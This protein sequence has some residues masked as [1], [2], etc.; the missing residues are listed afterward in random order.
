MVVVRV[1]FGEGLELKNDQ[2]Q[3]GAIVT[4]GKHLSEKVRERRSAEGWAE[5][6]ECIAP[7]VSDTLVPVRCDATRGKFLAG[8]VA[9][10]RKDQRGSARGLLMMHVRQDG[11]ADR[12]P[13]QN[14]AFARCHI[15]D[16]FPARL[17]HI[18]HGQPRR[19]FRRS[20]VSRNIDGDA[21]IPR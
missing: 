4:L 11:R 14:C 21:A 2:L 6:L 20:T 3:V 5:I 18:I 1:R 13:D 10:A 17:R 9:G 8:I 19:G 15:V 7:A 16:R 12:A